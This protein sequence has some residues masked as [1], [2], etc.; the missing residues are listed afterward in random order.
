[1]ASHLTFERTLARCLP[2]SI[3]KVAQNEATNRRN[4]DK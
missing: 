1:M 3:Y 2:I 4:G